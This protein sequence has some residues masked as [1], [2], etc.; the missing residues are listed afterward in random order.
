MKTV[1]RNFVCATALFGMAAVGS[2]A[3]ADPI[4][5]ASPRDWIPL[6]AGTGVF[7][8][9]LI[10]SRAG[11]VYAENDKIPGVSAR[12]N[13]GLLR[14]LYYLDFAGF[15]MEPEIILPVFRASVSGAGPTTQNM[16]GIGDTL[17]G[18]QVVLINNEQDKFWLSWEPYLVIPTGT[19]QR[20]NAAS[21]GSR[22][23][24]TLQDIAVTKGFGNGN[25]VTLMGEYEYDGNNTHLA[26]PDRKLQT[27]PTYR[28]MAFAS[29][30]ITDRSYVGFRF[31]YTTGGRQIVDG[32][33]A[34][35]RAGDFDW[36]VNYT[37]MVGEVD[38]L[39]VM[40]FDT[41]KTKNNPAWSG[42]QLRWAHLF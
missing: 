18:N 22:Q 24:S 37:T 21:L 42:F 23:W 19:Y 30:D 16:T 25:Y 17:L 2:V 7:L 14:G 35:S 33:Q 29:K 31:Q 5:Q 10:T 6:P 36:S 41:I 3:S 40:Y 28:V 27:E 38:Q 26:A 13:G 4:A 12:L 15:R 8:T 34:A 1:W 20:G 32:V 39:E 9:Y 11:D